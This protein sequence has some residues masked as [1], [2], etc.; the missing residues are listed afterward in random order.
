M[1]ESSDT[2]THTHTH[3]HTLIYIYIYIYILDW[4][5]FGCIRIDSV[6]LQMA[7]YEIIRE[8]LLKI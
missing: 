5:I 2:H 7:V 6:T 1:V 3:T 8:V 4:V